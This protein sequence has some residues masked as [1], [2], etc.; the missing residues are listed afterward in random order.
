M[1]D[2]LGAVQQPRCGGC[3]VVM[4]DRPNGCQCP[5]CGVVESVELVDVDELPVFT[6]PT[7]HGG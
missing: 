7:I 1:D 4:R 2:E 6:G 5:V 3:G